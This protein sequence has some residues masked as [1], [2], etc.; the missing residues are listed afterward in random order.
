MPF[1]QVVLVGGLAPALGAD[2]FTFTDGT[3]FAAMPMV[4]EKLAPARRDTCM[5]DLSVDCWSSSSARNSTSDLT[6]SSRVNDRKIAAALRESSMVEIR[7]RRDR[8]DDQTC[9]PLL[10]LSDMEDPM[11]RTKRVLGVGPDCAYDMNSCMAGT[12]G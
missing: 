5:V 11:R 2:R 6:F 9:I 7:S 8:Q 12:V 10:Y 4:C 3:P 1:V